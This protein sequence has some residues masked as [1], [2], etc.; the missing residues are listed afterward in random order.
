MAHA[1]WSAAF[2][3]QATMAKCMSPAIL[4]MPTAGFYG[5][6]GQG[7]KLPPVAWGPMAGGSSSAGVFAASGRLGL[8]GCLPWSSVP[9]GT[10]ASSV[11]WGTAASTWALSSLAG[12]INAAIKQR[13][14]ATAVFLCTTKAVA[15]DAITQV[16]IQGQPELDTARLGVFLTFGC[17]YQ[18]VFQYF[19]W[20]VAFERLWPGAS[21]R[22]NLMKLAATTLIADPVIFFPT[23]YIVQEVFSDRSLTLREAV[24]MALTKYRMNCTSDWLASWS[25]WVPGHY[26]TYFWM[27]LHLRMPWVA[28]ASFCYISIFSYLRGGAAVPV[29]VPDSIPRVEQ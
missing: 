27:P 5:W 16:V 19:L 22:A 12:W 20:N 3:Q 11:L 4:G 2:A 13:P 24:G 7:H 9:W 23:F 10:A 18:G 25:F 1:A 6:N 29:E 14:L 15:A 21:F 28:C 8:V 26:V 17:L